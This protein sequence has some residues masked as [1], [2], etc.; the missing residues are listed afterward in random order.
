MLPMLSSTILNVHTNTIPLTI[1]KSHG[2]RG[3][4]YKTEPQHKFK[5]QIKVW[6]KVLGSG[7]LQVSWWTSG[8]RSRASCA[9]LPMS[10]FSV[11]QNCRSLVRMVWGCLCCS[12]GAAPSEQQVWRPPDLQHAVPQSWRIWNYCVSP[13]LHGVQPYHMPWSSFLCSVCV[14]PHQATGPKPATH[15]CIKDGPPCPNPLN[16]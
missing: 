15:Q 9:S 1:W 7:S 13:G 3:P 6:L 10:P 11:T 5:E 2:W 14:H 16:L 4:I 8:L 12:E